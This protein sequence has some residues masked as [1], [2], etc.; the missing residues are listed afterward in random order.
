MAHKQLPPYVTKFFNVE[1]LGYFEAGSLRIGTLEWY[2]SEEN[3]TMQGARFDDG[4]GAHTAQYSTSGE[5]A[6]DIDIPGFSVDEGSS[7]M[8][9]HCH[10]E[11]KQNAYVLCTAMGGYSTELHRSLLCPSGNGYPGDERL[12]GYVTFRTEQLLNA[13]GVI[14][15]RDFNLPPP[16][17]QAPWLTFDPV[18]Y[19]GR[20]RFQSVA[21][22][23]RGLSWSPVFT[24]PPFFRPEQ[25]FRIAL[26]KN[27]PMDVQ[28]TATPFNLEGPEIL[29]AMCFR[30]ALISDEER[31]VW[32]SDSIK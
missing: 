18:Q 29:Q 21:T 1:S 20:S 3:R 6:Q 8:L 24:K 26:N 27:F 25:E 16:S 31:S 12:T 17:L 10:N 23:Q 4:E 11:G 15:M 2:S 7:A 28:D 14:A 13:L 30:P 32:L 22:G 5:Y 19:G 9:D